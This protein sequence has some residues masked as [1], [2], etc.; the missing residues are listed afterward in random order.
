[1]DKVFT[2]K[3]IKWTGDG[4]HAALPTVS[5]GKLQAAPAFV[6]V[7]LPPELAARALELGAAVPIDDERARTQRGTRPWAHPKMRF[8]V[9]L[10]E[11]AEQESPD[12]ETN[13]QP[14]VVGTH[15]EPL[16]RGKPFT[17]TI[18]RGTV[19]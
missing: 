10:D 4:K 13:N 2:V 1:M 16:D 19:Q 9:A 15:F 8:C 6:D 11:G 5:V 12:D 3:P 7:M 17:V 14:A 18:P